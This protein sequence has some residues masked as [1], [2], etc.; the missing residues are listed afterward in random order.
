MTDYVPAIAFAMIGQALG[1]MDESFDWLEKAVD[2]HDL[3]HLDLFRALYDSP[4][5]HPRFRT[6]LRKM[7]LEP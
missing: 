5:S 4:S 7:N 2:E 3:F 6:L 1:Q